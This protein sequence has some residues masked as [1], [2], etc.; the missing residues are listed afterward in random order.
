MLEKINYFVKN[1]K[2]D[3]YLELFNKAN[4]VCDEILCE[5]L[6]HLGVRGYKYD[7]TEAIEEL[8][9]DQE[10]VEQLV[11]DYVEQVIKAIVQFEA[12]MK[13]L[14][15]SQE[16]HITLDYT[17]FRELAHKNLGVARNLRIKDAQV[18][19]YELMKKDELEYLVECLEALKYCAIKLKPRRA[20]Y[21]IR[22]LEIKSNLS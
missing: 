10:L 3:S 4:Q 7:P 18:L 5:K 12:Y 21:T 17:P 11:E 15:N 19:L 20:Y 22:L 8:G 2:T 6:S 16:N 14:Q 1:V 13:K 9:L